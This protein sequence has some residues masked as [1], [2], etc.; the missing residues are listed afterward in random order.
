MIVTLL[1]TGTSFGVPMVGCNC[2]VCTSSRSENKRLRVSAL[3]QQGD[4]NLLVDCSPDFRQQA[5]RHN[6]TQVNAILFTH[7]HSDHIM[8]IDDLRI[9]NWRQKKP[10]QVYGQD[11]VIEDIKTRFSYCF[12]PHRYEGAAPKLDLHILDGNEFELGPFHIV[13]VLAKHWN[14][15]IYGYRIG[16]LGYMTDC[17][18]IPRESIEKLIGVEILVINALRPN[19]HPAHFSLTQAIEVANKIKPQRAYFTHI[20]HKLEHHSTNAMLQQ[21]NELA[22]DGLSF[23]LS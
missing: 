9:Y 12:L 1:G 7:N 20:S 22:Y 4:Y 21:D 18:Y 2:D 19:P 6:I 3:I 15:P 17:S 23:E 8:G 5:L 14:L 13:P 10:V 16:N 11:Y